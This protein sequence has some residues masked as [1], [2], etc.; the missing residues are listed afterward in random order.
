MRKIELVSW[1]DIPKRVESIRRSM[2]EI[3]GVELTVEFKMVPLD[4]LYPTESFLEKDK[5]AL[6]FMKVIKEGYKVPIIAVKSDRD[7]FILDG[8][9]RSFIS[10]KLMEKK[11]GAYILRFPKSKGYRVHLK[12][13]LERLPIKDVAAVDDPILRAWGQILTLLKYYEALYHVSF[14]F[15][16]RDVP[17][18]SLVPTQPQTRKKQ[19]ASIK[20]L[21][22]PIVCI[23]YQDRFYILDGH[24]RSLRAKQLELNS[25]EAIV[26]SP[27]IKI[28][29]GIVMTARE[30][31]LKC[32][33]DIEII[34]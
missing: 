29:F 14:N 34:D 18:N 26:L 32:L 31:G 27:E 7:Y 9:H 30:M 5:L 12:R 15:R 13:P 33:E 10:K 28:D 25:I 6:I 20:R 21:L 24:A 2:E 3:Y 11:I 8:H 16:M 22:V 23:E 4:C 1:R 19:I 17:L